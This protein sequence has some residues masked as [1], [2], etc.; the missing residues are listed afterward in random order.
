MLGREIR[1]KLPDITLE[2][3]SRQSSEVCD[4]FDQYQ[5]RMKNYH[6]KKD[7]AVPHNFKVGDKVLV[8][9]LRGDFS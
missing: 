9:H 2:G 6:D 5:E 3:R 1:T 8:Y 4:R 7:R